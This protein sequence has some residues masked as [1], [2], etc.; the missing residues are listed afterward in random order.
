MKTS[1]IIF[2]IAG[3]ILLILSFFVY[4]TT[5]NAVDSGGSIE[6][7]TWMHGK[8]TFKLF[9]YVGGVFLILSALF[10]LVR[11]NKGYKAHYEEK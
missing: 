2:G 5:G 6:V 8:W 7:V 1:S 10:Y 11:N 3:A 4:K 9:M